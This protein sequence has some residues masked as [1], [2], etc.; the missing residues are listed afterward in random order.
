MGSFTSFLC[1]FNLILNGVSFSPTYCRLPTYYYALHK[2][3]CIFCLTACIVKYLPSFVCLLALECCCSFS[4]VCNI[5]FQL[6]IYMVSIYRLLKSL[7]FSW[8]FHF[9]SNVLQQFLG[10]FCYWF[11]FEKFLKL[12]FNYT[13]FQ[14][15]LM[16]F[17]IFGRN[18]LYIITRSIL[19][20]FF[21][22]TFFVIRSILLS[23]LILSRCSF[24]NDGWYPCFMKL[25][26][27]SLRLLFKS[28]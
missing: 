1:L 7:N 5:Y 15:F 23:R 27:I 16:V 14:F 26:F 19:P 13:I 18:R 9:L 20:D 28:T 4:L 21:R 10:C 12:S 17:M 22:M 8:P 2:I 3:N 25:F 11:I 6:L 24:I